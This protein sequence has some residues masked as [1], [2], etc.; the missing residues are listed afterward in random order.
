LLVEINQSLAKTQ[1]I[2]KISSH[3]DELQTMEV[4][5]GMTLYRSHLPFINIFFMIQ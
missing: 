1:C 2:L 3:G 4:E 5:D